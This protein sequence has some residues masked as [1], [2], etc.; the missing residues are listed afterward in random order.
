MTASLK[1]RLN[2]LETAIKPLSLF[3]WLTPDER[4]ALAIAELKYRHIPE[5]AERAAREELE[6]V[7]ELSPE[8]AERPQR[9]LN[10]AL[11]A[12]DRVRELEAEG[13]LQ[14]IVESLKAKGVWPD[15]RNH[16]K[17]AGKA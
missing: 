4:A 1:R 2:S 10:L 6:L 16:Q 7:R 15:E 8:E 11:A 14:G 3:L 9:I 5:W 17:P 12:N 13:R